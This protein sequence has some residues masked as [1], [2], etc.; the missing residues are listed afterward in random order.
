MEIRRS[1]QPGSLPPTMDGQDESYSDLTGKSFSK[2]ES[3][4]QNEILSNIAEELADTVSTFGRASKFGRK[5]DSFDNDTV[6]AILEEN[7]EEKIFILI[8]QITK[9]QGQ[10]SI[11]NYA[12]Q[13]FPN[14]WDLFQALREILLSRKL[15]ELQKK[16]VREALVDLRNFGDQ[17]KIKSSINV[18]FVA[19]RF[20]ENR[21]GNKVTAKELRNSYLRF[22]ELEVPATY[23]YHDW[24]DEFGFNNRKR[25]LLFTR[26][27]LIADMKAN[28]PGLHVNEFGP[29]SARISDARILHTLDLKLTSSFKDFAFSSFAGHSEILFSEEHILTLFLTGLINCDA[30]GPVFD[31]FKNDFMYGMTL[32]RQAIAVQMIKNVY[33]LTPEF[34]YANLAYQEATIDFLTEELNSLHEKE[35]NLVTYD[36]CFR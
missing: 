25:V 12:R 17:K 24:I 33:N 22:L 36:R 10:T 2:S 31:K 1:Y 32:N 8:K 3:T 9:F 16:K 4:D 30:L 18:A 26:S 14:E 11:L 35:R 19:R 7:A 23:I 21:N 15:S 27:A 29:I 20:S 28:E 13:F 5:N 34:L 6:S